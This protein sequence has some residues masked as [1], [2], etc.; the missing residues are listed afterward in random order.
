MYFKISFQFKRQLRAE[1][2]VLPYSVRDFAVPAN[3]ERND[4]LWEILLELSTH[5]E[6]RVW[7]P[8]EWLQNNAAW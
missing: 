8:D 1:N 4:V 7:Q 5:D 6:V 2:K 3:L